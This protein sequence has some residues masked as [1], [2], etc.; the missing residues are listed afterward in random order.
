[1]KSRTSA[2]VGAIPEMI[3]DCRLIVF[4]CGCASKSVQGLKD[5]CGDGSYVSLS[6]NFRNVRARYTMD[7]LVMQKLHLYR[8]QSG[9]A[10]AIQILQESWRAVC[11]N[12]QRAEMAHYLSDRFL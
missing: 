8:D 5:T 10:K 1:M 4:A 7:Q 6:R 11:E 3:R 9:I 2:H 12:S